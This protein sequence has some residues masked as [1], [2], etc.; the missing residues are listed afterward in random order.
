LSVVENGVIRQLS[1]SQAERFDPKQK[2][3]CPRAWWFENVQGRRPEETRAKTDGDLGHELLAM[4]FRTGKPPEGRVRMG[5]AVRAA[6]AKGGLPTPGPDLEVERRFSGQPQR[7]PEGRWVPLDTSKT[8][9]LGGLP[10][11]GM[12]DLRYRRSDVVDVLDHKF[13]SDI[14]AAWILRAKDLI[15][16]IQMPVYALDALRQWPDATQFRF[17]HHNVSRKGADSALQTTEVITLDRLREREADVVRVVGEMKV[18][19]TVKSQ[20]DV[21]FNRKACDAYMGCPHQSICKGFKERKKVEMTPEE[22]ALFDGLDETPAA[23]TSAPEV[24]P[25]ADFVETPAPAAPQPVATKPKMIIEDQ[26]TVPD[27]ELKAARAADKP[28]I[29]VRCSHNFGPRPPGHQICMTQCPNVNAHGADCP[30]C[31]HPLTLIH[32]GTFCPNAVKHVAKVVPPDAPKNDVNV[33]APEKAKRGKK[34][35]AETPE[36]AAAPLPAAAPV[37]VTFGVAPPPPQRS[38]SALV[39]ALM[40]GS[41]PQQRI[42]VVI[43]IDPENL[44]AILNL[45]SGW[46]P[47]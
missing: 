19:A 22:M 33:P 1:V 37:E 42:E 30:E 3:G 13:S 2:A 44:R 26:S 18:V 45:L 10:W 20:D 36:P 21:P 32:G 5:K 9:W 12:I 43:K 46:K 47:A 15:N 16:T 25:F 7:T 17:T 29:C 28:I 27:A 11:D 41:T 24:D 39:R 14:H 35:K 31:A 23:V 40:D 4:Y 38:E 34:A 8:L 6:I